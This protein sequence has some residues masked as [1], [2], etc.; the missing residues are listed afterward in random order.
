MSNLFL[1]CYTCFIVTHLAVS[2]LGD[3]LEG[4]PIKYGKFPFY[5]NFSIPFG[6]NY[7]M[8]SSIFPSEMSSNKS[9]YLQPGIGRG[10]L[11][12]PLRFFLF[13]CLKAI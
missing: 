4:I 13:D 9:Y 8:F 2:I 3:G 6:S 5:P 7:S 10:I 11:V 12:A 1:L